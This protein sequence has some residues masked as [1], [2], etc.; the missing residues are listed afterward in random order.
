MNLLS[1]G[2]RSNR[3]TMS[4]LSTPILIM[5]LVTGSSCVSKGTYEKLAT[6]R[7]SIQ[8]DLTS[9]KADLSS[10][11]IERDRL[12]T[13]L[14]AT[15]AGLSSITAQR[16]SLNSQLATANANL[17]SMTAER[18]RLNNE[19]TALKA[20]PSPTPSLADAVSRVRPAIVRIQNSQGGEGSGFVYD[21]RGLILTASHVLGPDIAV[22][23]TVG[24]TMQL[25]GV[26]AGRNDVLDVAVVKLSPWG[27]IFALELGDS[28]QVAVGEDV[29]AVGYPFGSELGGQATVTKGIVSAKRSLEGD[30][31]I[32]TDAPINPGNSGGPLLNMLG[33]V[34]GINTAKADV[35][36]FMFFSPIE[37]IGL[38]TPINAVTAQL[39][40]LEAGG[41]IKAP[42]PTPTRAPAA[43]PTPAPGVT[44]YSNALWRYSIQ[45][46]G[47]WTVDDANKDAVAIRSQDLR[48]IV[49][50]LAAFGTGY[51]LESH[52]ARVVSFRHSI[53]STSEELSRTRFTLPGR[54]PAYSVVTRYTLTT[55]A[56]PSRCLQVITV[57][58]GKGF[59]VLATTWDANWD[60]YAA[61]FQQ[62]AFSLVFAD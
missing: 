29:I 39:P 16:D 14:T 23:V 60:T 17:S 33:Q 58:G 50:I 48:A 18:D 61:Q 59:E 13:D 9:T 5:L 32:Q 45:V 26:V 38:A 15:R 7:S 55:G 30:Q 3:L 24:D 35:M 1:T 34:I 41:F 52:L 54:L 20:A 47:G 36:F 31:Y 42:S 62:I 27:D 21:K 10:I 49:Q 56:Q 11:T 51:T 25:Q 53:W 6:E 28:D 44:L 22:K 43:T 8:S 57:K 37:G 2:R 46:P 40:F 4:L 19:L 12:N